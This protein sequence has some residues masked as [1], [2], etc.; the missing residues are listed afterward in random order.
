MKQIRKI[1]KLIIVV[2]FQK[3][4]INEFELEEWLTLLNK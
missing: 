4:L 2:L 3:K 1:L